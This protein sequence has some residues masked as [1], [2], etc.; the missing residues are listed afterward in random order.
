MTSQQR[1]RG[2]LDCLDQRIDDCLERYNHLRESLPSTWGSVPGPAGPVLETL[3][4]REESNRLTSDAPDCTLAPIE[5]ALALVE[6]WLAR[7]MVQSKRWA[8]SDAW[9]ESRALASLDLTAEPYE[10]WASEGKVH[11]EPDEMEGPGEGELLAAAFLNGETTIAD[12]YEEAIRYR[13]FEELQA[14]LGRTEAQKAADM[15][16]FRVKHVCPGCGGHPDPRGLSSI[17]A[18]AL[19]LLT[20]IRWSDDIP[21]EGLEAALDAAIGLVS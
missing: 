18:K 12:A 21:P 10:L 15:K 16:A 6:A 19:Q 13:C 5:L 14:I 8:R 9:P 17:D 4:S 3:L 2:R 1:Q 20:L 11:S 7:A